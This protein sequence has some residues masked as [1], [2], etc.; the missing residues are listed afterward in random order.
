MKKEKQFLDAS[1]TGD[2]LCV[3]ASQI[4]RWAK[5]GK[6]PHIKLPSG[7]FRFDLDAV[8]AELE[9]GGRKIGER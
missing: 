4:L 7:R 2:A 1:D 3:G 6:I 5:Q 8:R 9:C